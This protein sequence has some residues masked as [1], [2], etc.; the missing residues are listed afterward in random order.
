MSHLP[1]Q[2]ATRAGPTH[3]EPSL[4]DLV[5]QLSS[6]IPELIRAEMRLAQAE[7]A[8]KGKK[9][10]M[11]LGMFSV[12]GLLAFFGVAASLAAAVLALALVMPAWAAA[13]V[14]AAVLFAVAAIAGAIGRK[15]VTQAAPPIPRQT[16]DNLKKDVATVKGQR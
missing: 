7:V 11:G 13:L 2:S 8:E 12:A 4:G 16:L 6:Q 3:A 9:A 10:G 15:K 5:S 1:P 14:V